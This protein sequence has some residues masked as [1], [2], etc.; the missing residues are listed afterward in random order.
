MLRIWDSFRFYLQH[1]TQHKVTYYTEQGK[2][3]STRQQA[4]HK[5]TDSVAL[6]KR[7]MSQQPTPWTSMVVNWRGR[8]CHFGIGKQITDQGL[9]CILLGINWCLGGCIWTRGKDMKQV[10]CFICKLVLWPSVNYLCL[11]MDVY[12]CNCG[13]RAWA[14][15]QG[16]GPSA[17]GRSSPSTTCHV[18]PL[19]CI[20]IIY[21]S[22]HLQNLHNTVLSEVE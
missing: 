7:P 21:T 8:H 4:T 5:T 11:S 15:L 12:I 16:R 22:A 1:L 20:H 14:S 10:E 13:M 3:H 19:P 18:I 9:W 17:L 2:Q 6:K